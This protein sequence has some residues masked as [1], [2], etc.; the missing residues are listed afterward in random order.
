[1]MTIF[2]YYYLVILSLSDLWYTNNM[3][4]IA[5]RGGLSLGPHSPKCH[6]FSLITRKNTV[7]NISI[8]ARLQI[9][10]VHPWSLFI[11]DIL[12]FQILSSFAS[13]VTRE[14]GLGTVSAT[15]RDSDLENVDFHQWR[16]QR[17]FVS[18]VWI[19]S[20]FTISI[21]KLD[22]FYSIKINRYNKI[23]IVISE[24][25]ESTFKVHNLHC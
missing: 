18:S 25:F 4:Q 5:A 17:I 20:H 6:A 21:N 23:V 11:L 8:L 22:R 3:R 13:P 1:M 15:D 24:T 10:V 2:S 19:L 14:I 12:N 9:W 16:H 7:W